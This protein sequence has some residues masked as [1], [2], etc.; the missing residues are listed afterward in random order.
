MEVDKAKRAANH[1]VHP[2]KEA[3]HTPNGAKILSLQPQPVLSQEPRTI[4]AL[5]SRPTLVTERRS[6]SQDSDDSPLVVIRQSVSILVQENL[7][8]P[9]SL[10]VL[11]LSHAVHQVQS[12]CKKMHPSLI[13]L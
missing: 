3:A 9:T 2:P 7:V 1:R 4:L 8:L 11:V 13:S 5:E 12:K 6:V 10:H